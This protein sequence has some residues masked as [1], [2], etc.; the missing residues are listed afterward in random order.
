VRRGLRVSVLLA[1]LLA[2]A[3]T[4]AL[5]KKK[6]T[7]VFWTRPDYATLHVDRIAL[8]PVATYDHDL[9]N[10]NLV[11]ATLGPAFRSTGYRWISGTSTRDLLRSRTGGD[12]LLKALQAGVLAQGRLDSLQAPALAAMLRCDA[13]LTVRVDLMERHEPDWSVAGK[14]YTDV[15]LTS[16]LVDSAG[17]LLW[18][19]SGGQTGEGAYY[20]PAANPV[21]V[22]NSGLERKPMSGQGG[23]PQYREV[24]PTL[25]ARWAP[26]FPPH[27]AAAPDSAARP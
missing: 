24:L 7:E 22:N 5:A 17:R 19:A 2:L 8:L 10:E 9:A 1:A 6:A 26:E 16:A 23:A 18:N 3:A 15:R 27:G 4:G 20:D 13:V 12:S 11:E 25:F 21:G 14:P